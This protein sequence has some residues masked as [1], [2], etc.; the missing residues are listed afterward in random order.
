MFTPKFLAEISHSKV[1]PEP[2]WLKYRKVL[3]QEIARHWLQ[4][5]PAASPNY[6]ALASVEAIFAHCLPEIAA[7]IATKHYPPYL[8]YIDDLLSLTRR[9]LTQSQPL[10]SEYIQ[11]ALCATRVS[12]GAQPFFLSK[13]PEIHPQLAKHGQKFVQ[14]LL[15]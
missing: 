4:L 12:F 5:T 2:L 1:A 15:K 6:W 7:Q 14:E 8:L 10:I 3:D 13:A 11:E 9:H